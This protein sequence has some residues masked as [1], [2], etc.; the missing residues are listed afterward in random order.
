M[1]CIFCKIV[2]GEIPSTKIWEDE[3]F[4]AFLDAHPVTEGHTL[5]IP[6][7]HFGNLQEL[8][9]DVLEK[10]LSAIKKVA[11]LIMK[12]YNAEGFN[13]SLNNGKVAGQ[14]VGHVHFHIIPRKTGDGKRGI[15][16]G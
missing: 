3:N 11:D 5:V 6:K 10:Y 4:F 13:L 16:I 2:S 12:K 14:V 15:Y 1:D 9:D 8:T 7:K